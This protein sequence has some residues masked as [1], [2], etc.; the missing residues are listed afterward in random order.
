MNVLLDCLPI[1]RKWGTITSE[2]K[3]G[4]Q[5]SISDTAA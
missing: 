5:G 2:V 1:D 3:A 4:V